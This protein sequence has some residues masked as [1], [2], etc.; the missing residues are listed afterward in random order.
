MFRLV[1]WIG[2]SL[3]ATIFAVSAAVAGV[4]RAIAPGSFFN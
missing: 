1:A 2:Y 3:S 4:E